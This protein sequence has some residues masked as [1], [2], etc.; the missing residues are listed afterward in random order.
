MTTY[1]D[2]GR[3]PSTTYYYQV[4]AYNS[5]G[6]S[7]ATPYATVNTPA[8]V[9]GPANNNFANRT[10][11][12]GTSATVTGTNVNATKETGEPN[13]AGFTGGK[14]VWWTWTAPNSGAVQIDT[15]G[16]SFDTILGVY[17]GSGVSALTYVAGDDGGG[18]AS[19]VSFNAVAGITYQIAVDGYGGASGNITLRMSR[20]GFVAPLQQLILGGHDYL[21]WVSSGGYAVSN[22]YSRGV[23]PRVGN[24]TSNPGDEYHH[25]GMDFQPSTTDPMQTIVSAPE[26]G[27]IEILTHRQAYEGYVV[28]LSGDSGVV[29][30]LAHLDYLD[31]NRVLDGQRVSAGQYLAR[32]APRER[33]GR[34]SSGPHLHYGVTYNGIYFDPAV[35][36]PLQGLR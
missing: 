23:D 26:S 22:Y 34:N 19:K 11:M 16:S 9:V 28:R 17:T 3:S 5:A 6:A 33:M 15:I 8:A 21:D 14:S 13:H 36:Y 2:S 24:P 29:H 35:L 12:S 27:V 20:I 30:I 10:T 32:L 4:A 18:G 7:S 25:N 31:P 1:A